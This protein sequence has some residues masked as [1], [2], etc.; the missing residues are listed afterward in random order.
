VETAYNF[1]LGLAGW[2]LDGL[3]D[4]VRSQARATLRKTIEAHLTDAGVLFGSATWLITAEA[5]GH[6]RSKIAAMP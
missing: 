1:V 5:T 3:D 2:M 6:I 4:A